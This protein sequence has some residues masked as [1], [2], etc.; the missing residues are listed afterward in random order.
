MPRRLA[1]QAEALSRIPDPRASIQCLSLEEPE[2]LHR[3]I[4]FILG[5]GDIGSAFSRSASSDGL[6]PLF[7]KLVRKRSI[8]DDDLL[9][10]HATLAPVTERGI[11]K[12]FMRCGGFDLS[13]ALYLPPPPEVLRGYFKDIGAY[14]G[15]MAADP[16]GWFV[17]AVASAVQILLVHPFEDGN[18]RVARAVFALC[19]CRSIGYDLNVVRELE[20]LWG[21]GCL[22]IHAISYR[23]I[24][25]KCWNKNT[26]EAL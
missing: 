18:G 16:D 9:T 24:V 21:E 22:L 25:E 19:G 7:S 4:P 26:F 3:A 17:G 5:G 10:L 2:F 8:R 15:G 6:G 23:V 20:R 1:P 11:R 14:L 12:T 13:S